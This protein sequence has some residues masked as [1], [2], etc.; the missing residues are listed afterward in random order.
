MPYTNKWMRI[1]NAE[2][3]NRRTDRQKIAKEERIETEA[4][5]DKKLQKK[6]EWSSSYYV[7]ALSFEALFFF[8]GNSSS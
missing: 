8:H 3:G 5:T 4:Q 2:E 7:C 6:K 1:T